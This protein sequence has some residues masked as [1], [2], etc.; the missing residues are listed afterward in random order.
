M[1]MEA[2]IRPLHL[3]CT[4]ERG[5]RSKGELIARVKE[6]LIKNLLQRYENQFQ[7]GGDC[8]TSQYTNNADGS[9]TALYTKLLDAVWQSESLIGWLSFPDESPLRGML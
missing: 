2:L 8:V 4:L 1:I 7:D 6:F 9:I 5:M 3:R